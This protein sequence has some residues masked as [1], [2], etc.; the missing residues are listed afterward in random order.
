[1]MRSLHSPL[2]E[3]EIDKAIDEIAQMHVEAACDWRKPF[4]A[5][6]RGICW[7]VVTRGD[8]RKMARA[9]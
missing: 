9:G 2:V 6:R 4:Y 3:K 7:A 1:M 5:N 8:A